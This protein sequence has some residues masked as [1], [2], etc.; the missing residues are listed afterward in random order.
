MILVRS[1]LHHDAGSAFDGDRNG[2]GCLHGPYTVC[3]Q[4]R[5]LHQT[6][7]KGTFLYSIRGTANVDIDLVIAPSFSH[8]SALG[9]CNRI[10]TTQLHS[11]R[12]LAGI[13]IEQVM[14]L[15]IEQGPGRNHFGE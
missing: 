1:T 8:R 2:A 7:S 9:Q 3:Y 15:A 11:D 12:M 5:L 6:G 14:L 13:K 10:I 4:F